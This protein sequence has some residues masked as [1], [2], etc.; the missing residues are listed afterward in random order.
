MSNE[1]QDIGLLHVQYIPGCFGGW[2]GEDQMM[3]W[4]I[5][6][7]CVLICLSIYLSIFKYTQLLQTISGYCEDLSAIEA[8]VWPL[9]TISPTFKTV[10]RGY[11]NQFTHKTGVTLTN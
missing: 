3:S 8:T 5:R 1:S 10:S 11:S 2:Q 7:I 9:T 4:S 6:S